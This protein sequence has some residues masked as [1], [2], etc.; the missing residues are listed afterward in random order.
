MFSALL[1]CP[2]SDIQHTSPALYTRTRE[3]EK[4]RDSARI[5]ALHDR[6]VTV[7]IRRIVTL[8]VPCSLTSFHD[9]IH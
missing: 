1:H 2:K 7:L 6:D 8:V 5:D 9:V 4:R 3:R